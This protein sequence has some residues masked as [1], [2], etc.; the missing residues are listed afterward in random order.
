MS[1]LYHSGED[2]TPDQ[3]DPNGEKGYPKT[4]KPGFIKW[5]VDDIEWGSGWTGN[6]FGFD[7][8]PQTAVR[9]VVGPW[10]PAWAGCV[11]GCECGYSGK[12][13]APGYANEP[14][15]GMPKPCGTKD[16]PCG[17]G[18]CCEAVNPNL[19]PAGSEAFKCPIYK[20]YQPWSYVTFNIAQMQFTPTMTDFPNH[21]YLPKSPKDSSTPLKLATSNRNRWLPEGKPFLVFPQEGS[22]KCPT[23]ITPPPST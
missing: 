6:Q 15:A 19:G 5:F 17:D 20:D 2:L 10:N 18:T 4:K 12:G 22:G 8:V 14:A 9:V 11:V 1:I 21:V 13:T 23:P 16:N 3:V 7:N